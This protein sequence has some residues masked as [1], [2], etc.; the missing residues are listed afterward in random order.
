MP[1]S[2]DV[3]VVDMPSE[4]KVGCPP[5]VGRHG[6]AVDA[7]AEGANLGDNVG[8]NI[9]ELHKN[10]IPRTGD[11]KVF[12]KDTTLGQARDFDAQAQVLDIPSEIKVGYSPIVGRPAAAVDAA[13]EGANPGDNVGLNIKDLH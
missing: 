5:F 12:K 6:A 7:A 11:V 4:I 9:K 2:G 13:A 10:N 8:L 1:R 3:K